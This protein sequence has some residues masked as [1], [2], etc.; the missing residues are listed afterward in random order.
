M[1]LPM[2]RIHSTPPR[3][4]QIRMHALSLLLVAASF[5]SAACPT[6]VGRPEP[7]ALGSIVTFEGRSY[8]VQRSLDNGWI[9]PADSWFW[10]ATT[11]TCEAPTPTPQPAP[12]P[13]PVVPVTAPGTSTGIDRTAFPGGIPIYA[14]LEGIPGGVDVAGREGTVEV[15]EL[16]HKVYLP[17]DADNGSIIGTRKHNSLVIRKRMDK[18]SPLLFQ[19]VCTG[20]T[21]PKV[22]LTYYEI[23][24]EGEEKPSQRITLTKVKIADYHLAN[25][26]ILGW[27][28]DVALR[29]ERITFEHFEGNIQHTDQ[30]NSR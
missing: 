29:Y 22:E 14:S 19:K 4:E 5:A 15:R 7:Y 1:E 10:S 24:D 16:T 3:L 18:S 2:I 11:Q 21:I 13:A 27:T 26:N 8:K 28:E 17:T 30:W 9:H 20:E 12:P 6:W 23:T 25:T